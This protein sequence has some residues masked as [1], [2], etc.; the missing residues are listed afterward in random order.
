MFKILILVLILIFSVLAWMNFAVGVP[1]IY[2]YETPSQEEPHRYGDA[3]KSI[4]EIQV[5]AFYFVPNDKA[6]AVFAHW[7][8][9]LENHLL[10]LQRFHEVQLQGKSHIRL[11]VYPEPV[12][13]EEKFIFYDSHDTARGN[14][15]GL[16][17]VALELEKRIMNPEGDLYEWLRNDSERTA[18]DYSVIL[19]MYEGVGASA[20]ENAAFISRLYFTDTQYESGIGASTLAHEFYHALGVPEGY[21]LEHA[22]PTTN[23]LMGVGRTRSIDNTFLNLAT[24]RKFGL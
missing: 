4:R 13:G 15:H 10:V 11:R 6:D 8:I 24:L 3:S 18:E 2:R 14:P 7:K 9:A 5:N 23:D 22:R 21:Q 17:T 16:R 12:I 1:K 19:I 20:S